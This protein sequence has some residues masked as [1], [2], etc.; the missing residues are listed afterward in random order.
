MFYNKYINN[1][2]NKDNIF[3][4][5]NVSFQKEILLMYLFVLIFDSF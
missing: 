2:C 5:A 3:V 4:L 1:F